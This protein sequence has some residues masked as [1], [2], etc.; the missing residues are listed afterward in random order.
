MQALVVKVGVEVRGAKVSLPG[1]SA[2]GVRAQPAPERARRSLLFSFL[3]GQLPA[4]LGAAL[5]LAGCPKAPPPPPPALPPAATVDGAPISIAALQREV[6][7]LRGL[8]LREPGTGGVQ[9]AAAQ[10]SSAEDPQTQ[11]QKA[12][13]TA[14]LARALLGPLIDQKLLAARG[15]QL[16]LAVSEAEVQRAT[17]ALAEEASRAG[18]PLPERLLRDGLTAEEL[19]EETRERLLAER[20]MAHDVRELGLEKPTPQEL[21]EYESAHRAEREVPEQVHVLHLFTSTPEKAKGLLDQLRRGAGFE[22]LARESGESPDARQGGDL[23]FI[24]RGLLPPPVDDALWALKPGQLSGV[25]RS[26]YGYH[27]VKQLARR[28]GHRRTDAEQREGFERKLV[29]EKRAVA[30]RTLL[31]GLREKAKI[32]IDDAALAKVR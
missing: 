10:T 28:P 16:G 22:V 6:D 17:D 7:R 15:R 23:G 21:K 1:P 26:A 18:G 32:A 30:E 24:A 13:D 9:Q 20:A 25:I 4:A 12:Q 11:A 5:L 19:H 27:L 31:E 2:P 3:A 8:A 14:A 29:S